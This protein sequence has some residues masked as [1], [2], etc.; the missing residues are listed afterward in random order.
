MLLHWYNLESAL[1]FMKNPVIPISWYLLKVT[2]YLQQLITDRITQV[3]CNFTTKNWIRDS[4]T[5]NG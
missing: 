5:A 1:M 3:S 2:A 4:D